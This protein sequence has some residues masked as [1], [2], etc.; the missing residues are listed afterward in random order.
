MEESRFMVVR[1][2]NGSERV[3]VAIEGYLGRS[4]GDGTVCILIA[5][6]VTGSYICD[7]SAQTYE[8]THK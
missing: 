8:H 3:D 2:G 5:L 1:V 4:Y 6:E 7:T